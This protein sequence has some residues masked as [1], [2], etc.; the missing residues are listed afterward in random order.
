MSSLSRLSREAN[1][2]V[3]N[4]LLFELMKKWNKELRPMIWVEQMMIKMISDMQVNHLITNSNNFWTG[5][6]EE[7]FYSASNFKEL[8]QSIC[9]TLDELNKK[10]NTI[11]ISDNRKMF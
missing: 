1:V 4:K 3:R 10:G 8:W 7:T 9:D 2:A 5:A 11:K 6:L